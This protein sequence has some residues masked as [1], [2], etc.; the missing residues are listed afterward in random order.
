MSGNLEFDH[1]ND[2][3]KNRNFGRLN[4]FIFLNHNL[5]HFRN[6][7]LNYFEFDYFECV[8]H[9]VLHYSNFNSLIFLWIWNSFCCPKLT[10]FFY[11]L[12]WN[13]NLNPLIILNLALRWGCHGYLL[14]LRLISSF[15]FLYPFIFHNFYKVNQF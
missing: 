5:G 11:P 8:I 3:F 4:I 1:L 15:Q 10:F 6:Q 7:I 9:N 13:F 12:Q 14:F 2:N